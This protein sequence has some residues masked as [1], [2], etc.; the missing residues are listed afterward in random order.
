[1]SVLI[2]GWEMP[3]NCGECEFHLIEDIA[4]ELIHQCR[5]KPGYIDNADIYRFPYDC[6]LVELPKKHGRLIDVDELIEFIENRYNVT[7][8]DDYEGGIKD[9]CTDILEKISDMPTVIEAEE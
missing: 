1:M 6:P 4:F 8:K 3:K 7:W 5:M 2:K 9:A